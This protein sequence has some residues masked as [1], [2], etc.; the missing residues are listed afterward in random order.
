MDGVTNKQMILR[1]SRLVLA[2]LM[3]AQYYAQ[4]EFEAVGI[5][6]TS[7]QYISLILYFLLAEFKRLPTSL[8]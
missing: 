2:E 6:Y 8:S 4:V 3:L 7:P 5:T 1:A